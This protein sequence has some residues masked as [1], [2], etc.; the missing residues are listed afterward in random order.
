ML[1]NFPALTSW[2]ARMDATGWGQPHEMEAE[3]AL[4]I[5]RRTEPRA[6]EREDPEDPN[7]LTPGTEVAICS[8][9]LPADI[10]HGTVVS[11]R[12]DEIA[13][14]HRTPECERV[15]LHFP[16]AGYQVRVESVEPS[17]P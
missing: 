10:V 4:D 17:H 13:I 9:D 12:A 2:L 1:G 8:D 6:E 5:A 7:G 14:L 16:R 11:L 15:A 3:T